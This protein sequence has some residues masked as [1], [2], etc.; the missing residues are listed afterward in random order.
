ML[1]NNKI[2]IIIGVLVCLQLSL[3]AQTSTTSPYSRYGYGVIADRSFGAGRSM[4]GIGYGL[5]SSKQ[6]NPMNPASYSSM[7]SL[8]FLFDVGASLQYSLLNDETNTHRNFSGNLM[9]LAIQFPVTR[10]IAMS[11]GILPYSHTGYKYDVINNDDDLAHYDVF[12]GNGGL[13][14]VYIG[15]SID[16]WKRRLALGANLGYLFGIIEH[17]SDVIYAKSDVSSLYT[18]EKIK[19]HDLKYE[20]GVQ[21][22][23]PLSRTERMTFG[24]TYSPKTKLNAVTYNLLSANEY[25]LFGLLKADTMYNMGYD[26][27]NSF[28]FGVSYEKDYKMIVAADVSLQEWSK[29]RFMDNNNTFNN[30]LK[31]AVGGEYLP[32]NFT[33]QY[34]SRIKYRAGLNYS[35]SYLKVNGFG[36]KEYGISLGAGFP[37]ID[38]RS[39]LNASFEYVKMVPEIKSLINEQYFRFSLS[40]TFNEM[41]FRKWKLD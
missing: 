18:M 28:G 16:I 36:Y 37:M 31:L 21:Y 25:F 19:L 13:N 40:F 11:A 10:K 35:N 38:N 22:T 9:Y 27:P 7:D 29:T 14:E 8:T 39:F 1:K 3:I 34:M 41:W 26:I 6:I 17:K 23:Q 5:R 30:R 24:V 32:N 15:L 2:S 12:S 4:G 33:R 20:F